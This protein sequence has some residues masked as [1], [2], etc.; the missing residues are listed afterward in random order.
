MKE[1]VAKIATTSVVGK[2]SCSGMAMLKYVIF[3]APM[4]PASS[5]A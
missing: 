4:F 2:G 3:E 1:T 5:A